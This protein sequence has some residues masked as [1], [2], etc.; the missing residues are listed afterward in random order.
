MERRADWAKVVRVWYRI[1]AFIQNPANREE[2]LEILSARVGLP[3]DEYAPF[4]AG[5]RLWKSSSARHRMTT[6]RSPP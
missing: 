6:P 1:V 4:L 2:M 3:P 5:T